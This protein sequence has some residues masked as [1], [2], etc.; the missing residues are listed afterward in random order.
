VFTGEVRPS[1]PAFVL[2]DP[3][4]RAV[5]PSARWGGAQEL[6]AD[7][8]VAAR[9]T[10][11]LAACGLPVGLLWWALAPRADIRVTS[12][13]LEPVGELP[14]ELSIADDSVLVLLLVGLGLLAGAL[15]WRLRRRRGVAVVVALA[16]GAT[17]AAFVAWQLGEL[18]APGPTEAELERVDAVVTTPLRLSALPALAAAPFSAL[19][20]YLLGVAATRTDD[21]GRTGP[22]PV[23]DASGAP[24]VPG[25]E[26]RAG[27]EPVDA[28]ARG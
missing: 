23:V 14:P 15:A 21:L 27:E 5:P 20:A 12:D 11:V 28:G 2:G 22:V 24:D 18:L 1:P 16:V 19:L 17:L 9:L 25:D 6:R 10:G 26:D 3:G 13:G 8:R 7:L 4:R